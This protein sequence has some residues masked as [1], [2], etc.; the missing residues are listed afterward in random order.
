[1][2]QVWREILSQGH[3]EWRGRIKNLESGEV[4]FFR[5]TASLHQVM[6]QMLPQEEIGDK[7]AG[8]DNSP[9]DT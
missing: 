6:V 1:M 2:L 4:R 7:D 9:A 8:G 5:S 3:S